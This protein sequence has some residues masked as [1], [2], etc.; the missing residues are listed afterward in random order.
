MTDVLTLGD[1]HQGQWY[2][3]DCGGTLPQGNFGSTPLTGGPLWA[4]LGK[5]DKPAAPA[6][7]PGVLAVQAAS[8]L[9]LPKPVVR[10]SPVET[11]RQVVGVPSWLWV[12]SSLWK[13]VESSAEVPGVEVV[14]TAT[15]SSVTWELGDGTVPVVCRGPGT[16]YGPGSDPDGESPDCGHTF[17]RA[18]AGEPGAVFRVVVTAHWSVSWS[19]A[20]QGGTFPDLTSRSVLPVKVV[21]VQS[22]VVAGAGH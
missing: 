14:A 21:E 18:S 15:P 19:G 8:R 4:D 12:E 5:G 17:E 6:V 20:G 16:P 10:M 11:A 2:E 22:L 1:G 7:D 3:L 9:E 13:P